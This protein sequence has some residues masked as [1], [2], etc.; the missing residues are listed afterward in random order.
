MT[1]KTYSFNIEVD[2]I[3]RLDAIVISPVSKSDIICDL[4]EYAL[5]SESYLESIVNNKLDVMKSKVD[6]I[7]QASLQRESNNI[8]A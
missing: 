8:T 6:S 5:N 3:N 1:R 4:L 2:L 7:H